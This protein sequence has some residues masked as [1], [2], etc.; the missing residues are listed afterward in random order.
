MSSIDSNSAS[1]YLKLLRNYQ[2]LAL[3]MAQILAQL[4]DKILLVLLIA[5][6]TST[7]YKDYP[8]PVNTRESLIMIATTLPAIF[9]GSIA[10]IFV[11][12]HPKRQVMIL[13]NVFRG[14]LVLLIPF[15]PKA[16]PLL[17]AATFLISALTQVFAPAEQSAIPSIVPESGLMSANALFTMTMMTSMIV[18]YAIGSPL[19][20]GL[21]A[22]L[23][24]FKDF[25][26]EL[27]L[28]GM[29]LLSGL[30][31]LVIP[32]NQEIVHPRAEGY[33]FWG[34]LIDGFKY[35]R[36]NKLIAGAMIQ[37]CV[38]YGI[39]SALMKLSMN[40][41]ELVTN[42]R[43][44][45]GYLIAAAGIGLAIGALLL[46]QFG[47]RFAHRPLPL[48]GFVGMAFALVMFAFVSN[49]WLSLIVSGFLGFHG[50]LIAVPMQTAIQ[51]YTPENMRGKVF[52]LLNNAENIAASLPLVL[53]AVA[54]DLSTSFFGQKLGFQIV[55]IACSLIVAFLGIWAWTH[56]HKA[57]EKVL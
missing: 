52:G 31:L 41:T 57:L 7:D 32:K 44:D 48:V 53:A 42:S 20:S 43:A 28:G 46:G 13:C 6:A 47:D 23:P 30:V 37:L 39:L 49:L 14:V 17:L 36:H 40:L 35:V 18:G 27:L 9:F 19:L 50:A 8:I 22:W 33:S 16:L 11:D 15:V 5:I 12:M 25:S 4:V 56:T 21:V 51:K 10:G 54:L 26:R 24:Q 34:D 3:W 1:G 29:Y 38:L 45:F 2:F 55:M